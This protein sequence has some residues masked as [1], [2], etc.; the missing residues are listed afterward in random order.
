VFRYKKWITNKQLLDFY[1][2]EIIKPKVK[3]K[4]KIPRNDQTSLQS[5]LNEK[6]TPAQG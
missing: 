2:Q 4:K 6:I 5:K 3:R 1:P